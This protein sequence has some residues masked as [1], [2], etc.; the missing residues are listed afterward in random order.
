MQLRNHD[1][2]EAILSY[3]RPPA[4][5]RIL[6]HTIR[7]LPSLQPLSPGERIRNGDVVEDIQTGTRERVTKQGFYGFLRGISVEKAKA[8][9][10][11]FDVLRLR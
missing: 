4:R 5:P 7:K 3:R 2:L 10:A 9:P 11:V 1:R 6:T 8:M